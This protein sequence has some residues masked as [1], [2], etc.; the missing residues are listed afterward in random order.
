MLT[1]GYSNGLKVIFRPLINDWKI[2]CEQYACGLGMRVATTHVHGLRHGLIDAQVHNQRAS[3][4]ENSRVSRK[5][6]PCKSETR[7]F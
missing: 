2:I 7:L 6:M 3:S 1:G 5:V 4:A